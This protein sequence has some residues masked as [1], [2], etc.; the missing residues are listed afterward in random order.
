[1]KKK[2][3]ALS[4][5]KDVDNAPRVKAK[6]EGYIAEK[7]IQKALEEGIPLKEDKKLVEFLSQIPLDH[8]IPPE[9]Y[10]AIAE[11]FAYI[12][13]MSKVDIKR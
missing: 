10:R 1:M 2:A 6:G 13:K 9:L 3:V 8:E 11:I 7:I 5:D 12:Y 4:Y